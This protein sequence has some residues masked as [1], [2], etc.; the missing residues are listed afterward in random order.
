[1]NV[2]CGKTAT[3]IKERTN[4]AE[5]ST[6]DAVVDFGALWTLCDDSSY[7]L[8][9][10]IIDEVD[11][12]MN[13]NDSAIPVDPAKSADLGQSQSREHAPQAAKTASTLKVSSEEID[14]LQSRFSS[15]IVKVGQKRKTGKPRQSNVK[16]DACDRL[17]LHVWDCGGQLEY[18][19]AQQLFL[20]KHAL[21]IL[22][23]NMADPDASARLVEW[24]QA[25]RSRWSKMKIFV[26][27]TK[28]D[29]VI[30][31]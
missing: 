16:N 29:L 30:F 2:L 24:L 23:V 12:R 10:Y 9:S 1:M 20:P 15:E 5:F 31:Y 21:Y 6:H 25:L 27:F 26:V 18:R 13:R 11:S 17:I 7:D 14:R 19:A 3:D 8:A 28:A 22:V 4:L